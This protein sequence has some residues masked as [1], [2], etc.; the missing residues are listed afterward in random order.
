[1]ARRPGS[2]IPEPPPPPSV[3]LARD[4]EHGAVV[5]RVRHGTW[6][7]V[8]RGGY[9]AEPATASVRALATMAAIHER[10][11]APHWFSHESA[12]LAW[13][14]PTWRA[15]GVTH[16]RQGSRPSS[17]RDPR[18]L[19]HGGL[20]D[21]DLLTT[22]HGLPVTGLTLT[23]VDCARTLPALDALVVADAA[24]RAGA[25]RG[26]A[27]GM[28]SSLRGRAGVARAR[29]VIELADE[30]AESVGETA[31]R[32]VLLRDG[33][34]QPQTQVPVLTRLGTFWGDLGWEEWK[35]LVEYDG[36]PKYRSTEDLVREKRRQD[37]L[38]EVGWRTVRV[39]KEDLRASARLGARVRR[40][41]PPE[42]GMV[43]RPCLAG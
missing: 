17:R 32:F 36:R 6:Q 12:A 28:L 39:V 22:V 18:I 25:D 21:P 1:M 13:G 38:T 31:T 7:R 3:F 14:L 42:A 37:A 2:A 8:T 29:A 10:L 40:L 26:H 34:P 35:L 5:A 19:R 30:G 15:P 43:R 24:L 23:L 33:L 9:V 27:L 16:L 41:L 4:H 11:T 20:V